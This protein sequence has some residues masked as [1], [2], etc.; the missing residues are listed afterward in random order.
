MGMGRVGAMALRAGAGVAKSGLRAAGT[1][2]KAAAGY[3]IASAMSSSPQQRQSN[4]IGSNDNVRQFPTGNG[5]ASGQGATTP[6]T[7]G[8]A[9]SSLPE[10]LGNNKDI[11][12]VLEDIKKNTL[13]TVAGVG[14]LVSKAEKVETVKPP[15]QEVKGGQTTMA[16]KGKMA[17]G[18]GGIAGLM[19]MG[20][21]FSGG[22]TGGV[23]DGL[24]EAAE[25]KLDDVEDSM[26]TRLAV[27]SAKLV[28]NIAGGGTKFVAKAAVAGV[29]KLSGI[30]S[31]TGAVKGARAASLLD[32]SGTPKAPPP[33]TGPLTK[34]GKP[35]MRF[36]VNKKAAAAAVA[37][38][39]KLKVAGDAIK[40]IPAARLAKAAVKGLATFGA[41]MVPAVGALAGA[42]MSIKRLLDG[43]M[44]GAM[45]EGAG[46]FLP[47]VAGMPLDIGLLARD[48]Y[49][50]IYGNPDAK[51]K[52]ERFPHDIDLKNQ[53]TSGY[54]ANY[55]QIKDY[56]SEAI[57]R[58]IDGMSGD[59][60]TVDA[61]PT[62][63][64]AFTFG[65][66]T[67]KN[68]LASNQKSWDDEHGATHNEDGTSK[69]SPQLSGSSVASPE[70]TPAP[71][72]KSAVT[73]AGAQTNAATAQSEMEQ[74]NA[75]FAA[76]GGN[77]TGGTGGG[78]AVVKPD[79]QII[80]VYKDTSNHMTDERLRGVMNA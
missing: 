62:E 12:D 60:G 14:A 50:D 71:N 6:V 73:I 10:N 45:A 63:A 29:N 5:V 16:G 48:M 43:D 55:G 75:Q 47:S 13:A 17:A 11:I 36:T 64:G 74:Q 76:N 20:L 49:N 68:E 66:E 61:R 15:Q 57:K 67:R 33:P 1:V 51:D 39:P 25:K 40:K 2:G 28:T 34:G 32:G 44:K 65:V 79:A 35:D 58:L 26:M 78:G 24:N 9:V 80:A 3:G 4:S 52:D 46:I 38:I 56:A 8:G 21:D 27:M 22:K 69:M 59:D 53:E 30:S 70:I 31:T 19:A 23:F 54:L 41:K 42:G 37:N 7:A 18:I 77:G 72:T